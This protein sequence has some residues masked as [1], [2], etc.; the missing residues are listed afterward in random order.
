MRTVTSADG[1][2]VVIEISG[3]GSPVVIVPGTIAPPVLYHPL[4]ELLA[5]K[6]QVVVVERRG[7]GDSDPGPRPCRIEYHAQDLAAV[8]SS[9]DEPATV[10]GHSFGALVALEAME[11]V[12]DRVRE[13]VLY[14]PPVGASDELMVALEKGRELVAAGRPGDAVAATLIATGSVPPDAQEAIA[15]MAT[16]FAPRAEGV[17]SDLECIAA[18]WQHWGKWGRITVPTLLLDGSESDP[19]EKEGMQTLLKALPSHAR[20]A[21]LPGQA[22]FPHD[23]TLLAPLLSNAS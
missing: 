21:E 12:A 8:L 15:Q 19:A 14:E 13:L 4:A 20:Y 18:D 22:H 23:M 3:T 7:Y 17:L 2:R 5:T 10:F 9:L 1:T 11:L 6:H 16:A